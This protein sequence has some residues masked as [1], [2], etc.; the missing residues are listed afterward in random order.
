[1]ELHK[2]KNGESDIAESDLTVLKCLFQD[3]RLTNQTITDV[4]AAFL[5]AGVEQVI[6]SLSLSQNSRAYSCWILIDLGASYF[7]RNIA[8]TVLH[9]YISKTLCASYYPP[10]SV[11][12][13]RKIKRVLL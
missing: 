5:F 6:L 13:I 12:L 10:I 4:M 2:S 11:N 8:M 1:M 9:K 7:F 3:N